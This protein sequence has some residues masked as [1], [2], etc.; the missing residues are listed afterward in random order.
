[1]YLEAIYIFPGSVYLFC[2]SQID[3]GIYKYIAHI[4]LNAGTGNEAAPF[5]FWA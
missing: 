4:Y 5:H 1:M 2:C 3:L